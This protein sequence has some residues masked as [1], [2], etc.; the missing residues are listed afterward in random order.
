MKTQKEIVEKIEAEKDGDFFGFFTNDLMSYLDFEHVKPY[1]KEGV[2]EDQ[3]EPEKLDRESILAK[4]HNYMEFAWEKANNFR[5]LS[6]GRSIDHYRAW[7]FLLGDENK[8][9]SL[10]D[11]QYYGKDKLV[12]ICEE[13]GW[14]S[15]RWDDGVRLNEEP[16]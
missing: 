7:I 3:W 5:G 8:F 10:P 14:D 4:M 11:Y 2:T 15:D 9:K 1:L 16:Y 13:Y 12:E 6:A